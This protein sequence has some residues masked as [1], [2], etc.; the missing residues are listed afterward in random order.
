[1]PSENEI[2]SALENAEQATPIP[3]SEKSE[4]K[5]TPLDA[6][7]KALAP[8]EILLPFKNPSGGDDVIIALKPLSPGKRFEI[9]ETIYSDNILG[10]VDANPNVDAEV[11]DSTEAMKALKDHYELALDLAQRQISDPPGITLE[12]LREWDDAY[13]GRIFSVLVF[14]VAANSAA[15]R[16]REESRKTL[17]QG[18]DSG[19]VDNMQGSEDSP[20]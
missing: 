17:Q 15:N 6:L 1:M 16:F 18:T 10:V 9:L 12:I 19:N 4:I 8:Q 11:Q 5:A 3:R 2:L 14:E 7:S 20:E 13:I